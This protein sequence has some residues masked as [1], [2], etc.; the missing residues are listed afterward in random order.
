MSD[1]GYIKELYESLS[2]RGIRIFK[3]VI[4]KGDRTEE[5]FWI[6]PNK[7]V[8]Q[9]RIDVKE[10][11][12]SPSTDTERGYAADGVFNDIYSRFGELG[13]IQLDDVIAD[14]FEG[15]ITNDLS[16]LVDDPEEDQKDGFGHYGMEA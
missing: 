10:V 16:R 11:M 4:N 5:L 1:F 9:W 13:Y 7:T 3:M 14:V 15:R 2:S 6:H 8:D 12:R